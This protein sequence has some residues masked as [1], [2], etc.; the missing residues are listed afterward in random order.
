MSTSRLR[1]TWRM[2]M[3]WT[4]TSYIESSSV[5]GSIPCDIV[6]FPWGSMSTA[7]HAVALLGEG[8]R[9]VQRRRRLRHATLLVGERDHLGLGFHAQACS[10]ASP[11]FPPSIAAGWDR[12][13]GT[14]RRASTLG[15]RRACGDAV[16]DL[17]DARRE[18]RGRRRALAAGARRADDARPTSRAARRRSSSS[19]AGG[20]WSW[21]DGAMYEVAAGDALVHLVDGEPHTLVAGDDGLDVLAFG[22]RR[23]ARRAH[24]AAAR[25]R[26]CGSATRGS[27]R[28]A[29]AHPFE[30]EAARRARRRSATVGRGRRTIVALDDVAAAHEPRGRDAV[31]PPRPRPRRGLGRGPASTTSRSRRARVAPAALPQRRGGAVRRARRRRRRACSA[32]S[33]HAVRARDRSS[34]AGRDRRRPLVR[35]PATTG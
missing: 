14:T 28:R 7:E 35:A 23:V 3:S 33:E 19:S 25:R 11:A 5:S 6:R 8:G 21:Q 15:R 13:T 30:R 20:G 22:E 26:R 9:E 18:R 1:M 2:S 32:T 27:R 17:G 34:P 31:V 24:V 16:R 10:R 29:G 12:F 4:S